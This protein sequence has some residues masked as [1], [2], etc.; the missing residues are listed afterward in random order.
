MKQLEKDIINS[1]GKTRKQGLNNLAQLTN[2]IE[3]N[4]G[5]S[6]L[7]SV[8]NLSYNYVLSGLK[9]SQPIILKLGLDITQLNQ[10]AIALD[11]FNGFGTVSV[12]EAQEGMLLL[13]RAVPGISLRR[14]FPEKDNEAIDITSECLKRL[15]RAPIPHSHPL[16]NIKDW[17]I[18]LDKDLRI[19][20][21]YLHKARVLRDELIATSATSVLLHG[22]LHHDNIV[23]NG[24]DWV[25]IDPKGV[26]GEPA[27]EVAALIRNPIPELLQHPDLANIIQNRITKFASRLKLAKRL[28]IHWSYVQSVLAWSWAL[29]DN[30]D[31]TYFRTLTALFNNHL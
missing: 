26:I 14:L 19:P 13:E 27:Y 1:Y 11:S 15:H 9:G 18:A 2:Q 3:A 4:Y 17:L 29:E 20:A 5:L 30:H 6:N 8:E 10:E 16:P 24:H 28:I 31:E 25:V 12:L 7:K 22:D 21:D 23:Q